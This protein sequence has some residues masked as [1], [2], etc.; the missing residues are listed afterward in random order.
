MSEEKGKIRHI[1]TRIISITALVIGTSAFGSGLVVVLTA[2]WHRIIPGAGG[3][4][5]FI[6]L[7]LKDMVY[8]IIFCFGNFWRPIA[9]VGL[10]L[11]IVTLFI[12]RNLI[13]R[14]YPLGLLI[15]GLC[16]LAAAYVIA[17]LMFLGG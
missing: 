2:L 15:V 5:D 4:Y 13:L 1:V 7:L 3:D 16:I 14:L 12:E 17:L 11:S 6:G 8:L 9:I 10:V